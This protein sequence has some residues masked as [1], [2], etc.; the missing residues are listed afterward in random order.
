MRSSLSKLETGG[1]KRNSASRRL[2]GE[3]NPKSRSAAGPSG[4][5]RPR[6]ATHEIVRRSGVLIRERREPDV[7]ALVRIALET[8]ETDQYPKYLPG[9]MRDFLVCDDAY[10]AWVA[11][12]DEVVLGQVALHHRSAPEVMAI[13]CQATGLSEEDLAVVARLVVSPTIRRAGVGRALFDVAWKEAA[14]RGLRAV[15]DVVTDHRA[16]VRLYQ[17]AGWEQAG[18]VTWNLPDGS[19]LTEMVFVSPADNGGETTGTN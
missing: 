13:A 16:A 3:A 12:L 18:I 11:T 10:G 17:D 2:G 19:P 15:L 7:E 5:M 8:H 14:R 1:R 9:S 4:P 6:R